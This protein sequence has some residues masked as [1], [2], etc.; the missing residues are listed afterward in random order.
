MPLFVINLYYMCVSVF[1]INCMY[2]FFFNVISV[3]LLKKNVICV[4]NDVCGYLCIQYKY[5]IT[6][7]NLIIR[8]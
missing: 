5:N 8:K 4:N 6:L 1:N 2:Y 3:N 7:Y